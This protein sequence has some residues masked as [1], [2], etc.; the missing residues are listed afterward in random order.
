MPDRLTQNMVPIS[1]A[2]LTLRHPLVIFAC[3]ELIYIALVR[4]LV[5][6]FNASFISLEL[7]WTALRLLS[8]FVLLALFRSIIWRAS[9]RRRFPAILIPISIAFLLIP[10][11]VG[12]LGIPAP[13]KY[14]F[15]ATSLVVGLRE[16]I[17]YRG[18][19]Q[20][21]IFDRHGLL[22]A[23]LA[24]NVLFV[25]YHFGTQPITVWGVFQWF[26]AGTILGMI[27]AASTF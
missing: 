12:H 22:I 7:A 25:F 23:I 17:A 8:L 18:I 1:R 10:L 16:E 3:V 11:L 26:A 15:A 21:L 14:I 13:A 20:R 4:V 5:L 6:N 27:Y 19:L 2:V 9:D 24:S